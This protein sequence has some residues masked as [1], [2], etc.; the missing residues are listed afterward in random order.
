MCLW[1][2]P[3]TRLTLQYLN[4]SAGGVR[5]GSGE[6]KAPGKQSKG[7]LRY[8]DEGPRTGQLQEGTQSRASAFGPE[9][10]TTL[11]SMV[12]SRSGSLPRVVSFEDQKAVRDDVVPKSSGAGRQSPIPDPWSTPPRSDLATVS[13]Q[14]S[15][16]SQYS[17]GD[18]SAL[19]TPATAGSQQPLL[20]GGNSSAFSPSPS[21]KGFMRLQSQEPKFK[22]QS[23]DDSRQAPP[24]V[25][26]VRG[27][28]TFSRELSGQLPTGSSRG[29][30]LQPATRSR[31]D[32]LEM[33]RSGS[34]RSTLDERE[35]K[36]E[37]EAARLKALEQHMRNAMAPKSKP[38]PAVKRH[39]EGGRPGPPSK[40]SK[41]SLEEML[42]L[43]EDARKLYP[44]GSE[45][46]VKLDR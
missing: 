38:D 20:G 34:A 39:A 41:P 14:P 22:F 2:L 13:K 6:L 40:T 18:G 32:K 1:A 12:M 42:V 29:A 9:S 4:A 17:E 37:K 25:M 44:Q 10:L 30:D 28:R 27:G 45:T 23:P 7:I 3:A 5:M 11:K 26:P 36:W 46:R 35:D 19:S 16:S 15:S 21:L 31:S 43:I 8:A 33:R 24:S